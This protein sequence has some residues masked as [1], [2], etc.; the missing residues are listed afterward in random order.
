MNVLK[1]LYDWV[2]S[3]SHT[4]YGTPL[5]AFLFFIEA[6]FFLPADPLLAVYC[7]EQQTK[8]WYF[9]TIATLAS[10]LGGIVSYGIGYWLW[11][12]VGNRFVHVFFSQQH[13]DK[14][15]S[16]FRYYQG[17]AVLLGGIPPV[18]FKLITLSAGFC[19]LPLIPFIMYASLGR[20]C[21]F[22]FYA[23]IFGTWGPVIKKYI[24][25]SFTTLVALGLGS[26]VLAVW[27]YCT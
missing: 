10:V 12:L 21:R 13:F 19:K 1:R 11:E 9:A 20:G 26:V 27:L 18:P 2:S 6:I 25:R 7:I 17:P 15:V 22:Y 24:D 16:L 8:A 4:R 5:L 23:L 3:Q 14:A